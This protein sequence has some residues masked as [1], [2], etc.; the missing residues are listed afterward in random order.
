M[1]GIDIM[2][3]MTNDKINLKILIPLFLMAIISIITIYSALT[4][5]S[6]S[7][8]NLALK[9]AIWYIVGSVLVFIILKLKNDFLYRHT[10]FLYILGNILLVGLLLFGTPINNSKCWF[11]IPGV[12]SIQPSEFMKVFVMLVLATM[13]HNFRSDYKNPSIKE[14]FLFIL[15]SLI[16]VLIPAI[17][18]FL[19][20]DT[21]AV[22]IYLVIYIVMMFASGIRFRWFVLGFLLVTLGIGSVLGIYFFKEE[23]FIDLFGTSIF[24]RL[25]RLFDWQNGSGFQ[26]E[27][28]LAAIGS[29]GLFGH[30]FNKTPIYFPESS[31]DFIF[32]VFASNFGII[33]VLILLS[34]IIYFDIELIKIGKRKIDD[35][36][37]YILAGVV[38]M[39]LFQ[40]IQ[41]IGMTVGLLPIT[42]ITLPFI[43]YGGSSLLSYMLLVGILLNISMEKEKKYKYR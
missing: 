33:G 43:S 26:L 24:Y 35:T 31:T 29:A 39:L 19:Q 12:G 15:K 34:I 25:D 36:N 37:K 18:T 6:Q 4:Y 28:A 23:L 22:I 21:G 20:P 17:L 14:E 10:W 32:A 8:G 2:K 30:G 7:L 38:G 27:N 13:I 42:G 41:N 40:Q 1:K 3:Y 16:V 11:T 5:T 9:Q